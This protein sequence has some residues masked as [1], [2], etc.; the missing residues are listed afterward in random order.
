MNKRDQIQQ[1]AIEATYGKNRGII[2]LPTGVGKTFT[3]FK[4]LYDRYKIGAKVLIL[5]ETTVRE[6][7]FMVDEAP[8]FEKIYHKNPYKD[9]II[10]HA[11]YQSMLDH[12]I[13]D[14]VIADEVH[15]AMSPVYHVQFVN[16]KV[17]TWGFTAT[18]MYDIQ[19]DFFTKRDLYIKCELHELYSYDVK[20]A[21]EEKILSP[22]K[23]ELI[24]TSLTS[25]ENREY[26]KWIWLWQNKR[27]KFAITKYC[28]VLYKAT[29]KI[30]IV[31]ELLE[32]HKNQ[33][34]LIMSVSLDIL[35]ELNI[36]IISSK[37]KGSK[38]LIDDFNTDKIKVLGSSKMIRQGITLEGLE[39][40]ILMSYEK[41][42]EKT[43]QKIGR[44]IRFTPNKIGLICI[45]YC[46]NTKEESWA[47]N[48]E[49]SLQ[50]ESLK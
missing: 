18:P 35:D 13:Y 25:Q 14:V 7:T 50:L 47:M 46:Q 27:L 19:Y 26:N 45:L 34:I 36:P 30:N 8:K 6:I 22:Y 29:N 9:F 28:N 16:N 48:L 21:I 5:A 31:K 17:D 41:S 33:K 37:H 10:T 3:V 12:S 44:V 15:D 38:S 20:D 23:I 2:V 40:L 1:K 4:L 43:Q 32:K 11:C 24:K 42:I 39:V 49:D